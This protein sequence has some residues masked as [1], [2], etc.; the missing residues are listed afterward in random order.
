MTMTHMPLASKL[1]KN[2]GQMTLHFRLSIKFDRVWA[3]TPYGA[4]Y[5]NPDLRHPTL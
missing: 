4:P 2:R 3:N 5:M 1:F